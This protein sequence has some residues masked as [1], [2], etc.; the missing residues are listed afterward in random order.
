MELLVF[1]A[2]PDGDDSSL[3]RPVA[4]ATPPLSV[5]RSEESTYVGGSD[6]RH[7]YMDG[8]RGPVVTG[9]HVPLTRGDVVVC[10]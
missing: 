1:W 5:V 10:W 4:V 9:G 6:V 8:H 3:D 2:D 7:V